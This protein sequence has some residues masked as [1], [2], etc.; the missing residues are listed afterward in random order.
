MLL[1]L[2][3][4]FAPAPP[5]SPPKPALPDV[6]ID[7]DDPDTCEPCHANVVGEWK[8]SMH[9]HAH[10]DRDPVYAA[11]RTMRM[12]K[13]GEQLAGQ[14]AQCHDPRS[15]GDL[16]TTAA[17]AGVS[18][19]ACHLADAIHPDRGPGAKALAFG[20]TMHGPHDL[21]P[22]ASPVH[23]TGSAP[24]H[25]K[26]G[27]TLCLACHSATKNPQGVAACTTGPEHAE[28]PDADSCVSCHMPRV[29]GPTGVAADR[30]DHASHRFRGPH[31]AWAGDP[32]FLA[33]GLELAAT[34]SGDQLEVTLKN[35]AGHGF[36]TGFPGRMV[37]VTAEGADADGESVWSSGPPTPQTLMN[38]V[39]VDA[40]GN[41]V[42]PPY[43]AELKADRRLKPDEQRTFVFTV[44][45]EVASA[46]ARVVMRLLPPPMAEKIG[47]G[48]TPEAEPRTIATVTATRAP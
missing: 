20:E 48:G 31:E 36:P 37:M 24:A 8:Q 35:L 45:P 46:E 34:L 5:A 6:V 41:P 39:Y 25:M 47:L 7:V 3:A 14:C 32:S 40:E 4:C 28:A 23:P 30:P 33:G 11:M 17:K 13:E 18:C 9:A 21:A 44:P 22:D 42:A 15:P 19:A 43:A 12:A 27:Q 2:T 16:D 1:F 26:D 10:H 29:E 38:K